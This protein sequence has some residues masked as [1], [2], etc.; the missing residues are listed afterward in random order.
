MGG[1]LLLVCQA[2]AQVWPPRWCWLWRL[3]AA[4]RHSSGQLTCSK[5]T[6]GGLFHGG[7]VDPCPAPVCAVQCAR[8]GL[9]VNIEHRLRWWL[10]TK[11]QGKGQEEKQEVA[12][13]EGEADRGRQR[14]S[15]RGAGRSR[16][17]PTAAQARSCRCGCCLQA[18]RPGQGGRSPRFSYRIIRVLVACPSKVAQMKAA[19]CCYMWVLERSE[20]DENWNYAVRKTRREPRYRIQYDSAEN[21]GSSLQTSSPHITLGLGV[22]RTPHATPL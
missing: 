11:E 16:W 9:L 6:R 4:C 13:A 17:R 22:P 15:P 8:V 3:W 2:P 21:S 7:H 19:R 10:P 18:S 20:S 12:K 1:M 5:L 14:G